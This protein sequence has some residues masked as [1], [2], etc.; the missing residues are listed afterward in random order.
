MTP[1]IDVLTEAG[2]DYKLHSYSHDRA[3]QSFGLEA[4]TKLKVRVPAM[5]ATMAS[6]LQAITPR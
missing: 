5:E 6:G 1:A 4:A 2:V 3:N